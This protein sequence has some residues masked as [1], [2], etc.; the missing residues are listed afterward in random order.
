[1]SELITAARRALSMMDLTT[2]NDDDTDAKVIALCQ[3]ARSS[4]GTVA[5]LCVF[6]RFVAL[7][8]RTLDELGLSQVKVATVTNFPAGGADI[9]AAVAETEAAIAAG[10]DEVDV[11]FPY[12]ALMA[13]NAAVGAELVAACKD[14]CGDKVLKVIIESGVLHESALIRQASLIAIEAGADFIKTSTGKVA[15]NATLE[16][17]GIML[18]AIRATGGHCGFK[19]AGGVRS[20]ADAAEYIDLAEHLLGESWVTAEHFRFGASSLLA[21]LQ[22]EIAGMRSAPASGY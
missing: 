21:S 19:A 2:L 10:A 13:G 16:A 20:A 5:A 18:A 7:T 22:A 6:P 17:A 9:A 11:V 12:R 1:M 3:Q 14:A 4:A 15:V 8:R